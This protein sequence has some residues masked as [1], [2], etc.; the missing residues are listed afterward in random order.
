M[1]LLALLLGT[2]YLNPLCLSFQIWS[3]G[4]NNRTYLTGLLWDLVNIM[5]SLEQCLALLILKVAEIQQ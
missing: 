2:Q 4:N 3:E 1:T 5:E